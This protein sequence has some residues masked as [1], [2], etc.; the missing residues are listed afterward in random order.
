MRE[1]SPGAQD[2]TSRMRSQC[3][4]LIHATELAIA[5]KKAEEERINAAK[6][7]AERERLRQE[8]ALKAERQK[9]LRARGVCSMGYAWLENPEHPKYKCAG[10]GHKCTL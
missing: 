5:E 9:Q 7:E 4:Q 3:P 10:G 2:I 6:E 1:K 8:F